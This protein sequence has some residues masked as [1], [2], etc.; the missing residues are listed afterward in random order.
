MFDAQFWKDKYTQTKERL[1]VLSQH[2][3]V[4]LT[5]EEMT[6]AFREKMNRGW[7]A[8]QFGFYVQ[9]LLKKKNGY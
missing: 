9:D 6:E 2:Q 4:G 1:D 5:K 7:D 8:Y 3:W